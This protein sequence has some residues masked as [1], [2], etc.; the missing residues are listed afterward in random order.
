MLIESLIPAALLNPMKIRHSLRTIAT[1]QVVTTLEGELG[2]ITKLDIDETN[3]AFRV[4]YEHP[5]PIREFLA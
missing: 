4:I 3:A 2:T 5:E 1:E